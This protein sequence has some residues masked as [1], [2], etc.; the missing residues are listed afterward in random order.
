[1]A[2]CKIRIQNADGHIGEAIRNMRKPVV[3]KMRRD[4]INSSIEQL[5]TLLEKEFQKHELPS[6]PEKADIL[7]MT[8]SFLQQHMARICGN[9]SHAHRE[10]YSKCFRT[11]SAFC[12]AMIRQRVIKEAAETFPQPS[13]GIR[14]RV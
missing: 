2:P 14:R 5:K 6:K 3:E 1:M 7:E 10:G 9:S 8:V 4:R 11:P 12:Q 13:N